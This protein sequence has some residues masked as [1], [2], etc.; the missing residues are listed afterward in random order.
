MGIPVFI[1]ACLLG[2]PCRYDGKSCPEPELIECFLHGSRS[3]VSLCP[4]TEGGLT[5]PR[6]PAE[7]QAGGKVINERG[8]DVTPYFIRGMERVCSLVERYR[9]QRAILKEYSPSCGCQEIYD[10]TFSGK[11]IPGKGVLAA[12]LEKT[13]VK[14]YNE[15]N[16]R[17]LLE[18]DS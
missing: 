8:E 9:V 7:L 10:G 1:S 6:L 14:I 15:K 2:V 11:R 16:W 5:I 18:S 13:G 3:F 17:A 12:K 4:E